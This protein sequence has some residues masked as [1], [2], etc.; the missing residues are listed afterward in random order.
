MWEVD[1]RGVVESE[2]TSIPLP[3][4]KGESPHLGNVG[5]VVWSPTDPNILISGCK[6]KG[7]GVVAVWDLRSPAAPVAMFTLPRTDVMHVAFHPSG[8][9]F[10]AVSPG[11]E[12]DEV[13]FYRLDAGV[14]VK[15]DD[16]MINGPGCGGGTE[17]QINSLRFGNGGKSVLGVTHD[18]ALN[19]WWFPVD[20]VVRDERPTKKARM[21]SPSPE[22]EEEKAGEVEDGAD[23]D[24]TPEPQAQAMAEGG[25]DDQEGGAEGEGEGEA[26]PEGDETKVAQVDGDADMADSASIP[27]PL[28]SVPASAAPSPPPTTPASPVKEGTP[29]P[30]PATD[31]ETAQDRER[32]EKERE[33][34]EKAT[35]DREAREREAAER[36]AREAHVR[37]IQLERG[38]R[39]VV[40]TGLLL[41]LGVDPRGR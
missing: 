20:P 1:A 7:D 33:R 21:N 29:A 6:G 8:T 12:R 38:V 9:Q 32:T 11:R 23:R 24:A 39:K 35:R 4:G 40:S 36:A 2:R 14:W 30:T 31:A 15:R 34:A 22:E 41:A 27:A 19:S 5:S 3:K 18:G 26:Q 13:L 28:A 10:A 37:S 17:E 16:V 25:E